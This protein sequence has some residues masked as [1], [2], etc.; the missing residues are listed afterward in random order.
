MHRFSSP[1][2]PDHPLP[3]I[4]DFRFNDAL[5]VIDYACL[6]GMFHWRTWSEVWHLDDTGTFRCYAKLSSFTG[7]RDYAKDPWPFREMRRTG[8]AQGG[9]G[10]RWLINEPRLT[11]MGRKPPNEG[12]ARA[13]QRLRRV[14]ADIGVDLV[15]CMLWS[16]EFRC[17]SLHEL[18]SGTTRWT[19]PAPA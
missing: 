17:W 4:E 15:D 14:L 7:I 1:A 2:D 8:L 19:S 10:T 3:R 16:D 18:T 9:C 5:D 6:E 13:F 11:S 12:D